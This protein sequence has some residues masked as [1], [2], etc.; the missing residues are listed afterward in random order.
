MTPLISIIIPVF[1]RE[2]IIKDTLNS[3]AGQTYVNWECIIVDDGSTDKTENTIEEYSQNDARFTFVK[4]PK[5]LE[6]GANACRNYGFTLAKGDYINWFDSDDIM[7]PNFLEEKVKQFKPEIDAVVHRNNYANYQLI[8]F[9]DSKFE[10][11]NGKSLFYNYAMEN[12]EIQTCGFMWKRSFLKD[13]ML[14]DASIQRYQDNEFHIR[15]LAVKTLKVKVLDMVLATIRSGDG[16]DSQISAK[17][18]VSS[19]KLFDVFYC[20]Y[21]SLKM[22]KEHNQSVDATFNKTLAKKA[23]WAFYAALGFDNSPIKRIKYFAKY[24]MK[25]QYI[26]SSPQITI[27]DAWKSQFYIIK[28]IFLG[29]FK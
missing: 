19:K 12:I 25:L 29:N 4:R 24:Y 15:M 21:Q 17:V 28:I 14:F 1:N 2:V 23:L 9:R 7:K 13:K 18:N 6:K 26:Y 27:M 5:H 16:H 11:E 10:F 20:R 8:E 3:I 22:A